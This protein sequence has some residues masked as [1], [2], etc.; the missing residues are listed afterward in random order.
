MAYGTIRWNEVIASRVRPRRMPRRNASVPLVAL[1][2]LTIGPLACTQ[3]P[4]PTPEP[5]SAAPVAEAE[6]KERPFDT[7]LQ[8][9]GCFLL[10][11]LSTGI[12]QASEAQSCDVPTSP[13]STF[14]IPNSLIGLETG[15]TAGAD[16]IRRFDLEKHAYA[17]WGREDL[18]LTQAVRQSVVWYFRE[19][20]AEV[21]PERMQA[22]LTRLDYGNAT[23]GDDVT[24]FWLDGSL[25]I[26]GREQL[27]FLRRM[28]TGELDVAP[29]H[30]RTL[31]AILTQ[32]LR[33]LET[34]VSD[35]SAYEAAWSSEVEAQFKTGTNDHEEG[36][37]TW[38]V[39][40]LRS[41]QRD[42]IF[43]SRV[44]SDQPI[45]NISPATEAALHELI[46]LG[47]L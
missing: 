10:L 17:Q 29:E 3:T 39:G 20:A 47:V 14:K 22:M 21:G 41:Q 34:R 19:L 6:A 30:V 26:S 16:A 36:S 45:S 27:D 1:L 18:T 24:L 42:M 11:D 37:V 8:H 35:P 28:Y 44:L 5:P 31:E 4:A 43:V 32:P 7:P 40:R 46:A 23:I 12:T 33:S 15:V 25:M 38:L 9:P 13:A 2:S